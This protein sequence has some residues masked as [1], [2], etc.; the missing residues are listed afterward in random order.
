MKRF[1]EILYAAVLLTVLSCSAVTASAQDREKEESKYASSFFKV[2]VKGGIDFISVN[3]FE[4]G[5]ISESVSNYTGFT[6]GVAFSFDLP[7]R[8][9][10]IQPELNY[11]SKGAFFRGENNVRFRTDYIELPVNIQAGLD[12]ILFRPF[13]MVSPYIGCAVYKQPGTLPWDHLNRFEYGIGI[14]GGIDFWKMQ[15]QVKYNWNIGGLVKNVS[16]SD[17]LRSVRKGNFRGLEVNLVFFF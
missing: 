2:G 8:G 15:L 4:L 10:T 7:V 5:Y 12:L 13:I 11:V 3:R 16:D 1:A 6:A 9:M 14:G 17:L